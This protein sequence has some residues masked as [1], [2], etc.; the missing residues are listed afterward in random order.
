MAKV[1]SLSRI[2][3]CNYFLFI[4]EW[5]RW[6]YS[7][8]VERSLSSFVIQDGVENGENGKRNGV[9]LDNGLW[10]ERLIQLHFNDNALTRA[11]RPEGLIFVL[12]PLLSATSDQMLIL[13]FAQSVATATRRYSDVRSRTFE[14]EE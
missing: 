10:K 3:K 5:A 4:H 13:E 12:R 11:T 2:L 8:I 7:S 14:V 1:M 9:L 6:M